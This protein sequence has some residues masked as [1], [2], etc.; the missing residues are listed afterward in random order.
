[1]EKFRISKKQVEQK[2]ME[3]NNC[4]SDKV[5]VY[6]TKEADSFIAV[7]INCLNVERVTKKELDAE[8]K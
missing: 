6:P 5:N 1:M 3:C 4:E 8:A 7:C 2:Y